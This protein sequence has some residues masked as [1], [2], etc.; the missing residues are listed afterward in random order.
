MEFE[1]LKP[2]LHGLGGRG[3]V[4]RDNE[5]DGRRS[6]KGILQGHPFELKGNWI[7]RFKVDV[8]SYLTITSTLTGIKG[9]WIRN[10]KN[11]DGTPKKQTFVT[12]L[13]LDAR[14]IPLRNP[15]ELGKIRGFVGNA[16]QVSVHLGVPRR[17]FRENVT[18]NP[19][20]APQTLL[21]VLLLVPNRI[22]L[23][24]DNPKRPHHGRSEGRS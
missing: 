11:V 5:A 15:I 24:D 21:H 10:F 20:I 8:R 9:M 3:E 2:R 23:R 13:L 6:Q 19:E 14:K 17:P 22:S 18:A 1:L 16:G 12:L 7:S 4:V